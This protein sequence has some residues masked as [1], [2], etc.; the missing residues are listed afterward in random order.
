MSSR[1]IP[2]LITCRA[3]ED[4]TNRQ[5]RD[6]DPESLQKLTPPHSSFHRSSSTHEWLNPIRSDAVFIV[7]ARCRLT[8][9]LSLFCSEK[10]F[11]NKKGEDFRPEHLFPHESISN[12]S[13]EHYWLRSLF[14][15]F[16]FHSF[17]ADFA[18]L[19]A[20]QSGTV[21]LLKPL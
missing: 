10:T 3:W 6:G 8:H 4:E 2:P 11:I 13:A 5:Q 9:N 20:E 12:R 1:H 15:P 16:V 18:L 19:R 17:I 21:E 7:A 14:V